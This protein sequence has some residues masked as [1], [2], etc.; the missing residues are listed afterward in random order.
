MTPNVIGMTTAVLRN[1]D[2]YRRTQKRKR[3]RCYSEMPTLLLRNGNAYGR[4]QKRKRLRLYSETPTPLLRN[5]DGPGGLK[6]GGCSAP[7]AAYPGLAGAA[8]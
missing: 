6:P 5:R 3:L 7:Q 1:R 2:D 4:T 8:G